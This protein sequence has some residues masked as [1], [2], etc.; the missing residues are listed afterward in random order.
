MGQP[1]DMEVPVQLS[2]NEIANLTCLWSLAPSVPPAA[3]S[4]HSLGAS[5]VTHTFSHH[6]MIQ[7]NLFTLQV[8]Q[9]QAFCY[10][11][12]EESQEQ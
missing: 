2:C 1:E 11:T 9:L 12:R 8:I 3:S 6:F 4:P 7:T 10:S 5:I